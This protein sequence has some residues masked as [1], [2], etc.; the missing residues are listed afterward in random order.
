[1]GNRLYQIGETRDE[2]GGSHYELVTESSGGN[3]PTVDIDRAP[4]IFAAVHEAISHGLIRSCHDLSEG[5]LAA[6]VAEMAFAG[7]FGIDANFQSLSSTGLNDTILLFS[8]SNTRFIAEVEPENQSAFETCFGGLPLFAIGTVTDGDSVRIADGTDGFLGGTLHVHHDGHALQISRRCSDGTTQELTVN[9]WDRVM[10]ADEILA[11]IIGGTTRT[12]FQN[13]FAL[14]LSELPQ[15]ATL[16]SDEVAERLY[17]ATLGADGRRLLSAMRDGEQRRQKLFGPDGKSG[18]LAGLMKRDAKIAAELDALGRQREEYDRLCRDRANL[19]GVISEMK[20]RQAGMQSQLRGHRYLQRVWD[21]WNQVQE[22]E[23]ELATLSSLAEFPADGLNRLMQLETEIDSESRC[24]RTL[25]QE[26]EQLE[27]KKTVLL[28]D[29]AVLKNIGILR[30]HIGER[31]RM[32]NAAAERDTIRQ[33]VATETATFDASCEKL[34]REWNRKR[35]DKVDTSPAS[36]LELLRAARVYQAAIVRRGRFRKLY[37]TASNSFGKLRAKVERQREEF[38]EQ[39]VDAAVT[40]ENR[41]L[42]QDEERRRLEQRIG[43]TKRRQSEL[44]QILEREQ[45]TD[46]IPRWFRWALWVF[47]VAGGLVA[48]IGLVT[49]FSL[50]AWSGMIL[51]LAGLTGLGVSRG[52]QLHTE[53]STQ[54]GLLTRRAEL[55]R[56]EQELRDSTTELERAITD[57]KSDDSV[58][59][60]TATLSDRV[61]RLVDLGTFHRSA[62]R[63]EKRRRRMTQLRNRFSSVKQEFSLARQ[64]WCDE[65]KRAGLDTTLKLDDV[66]Y[67]NSELMN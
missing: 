61:G 15:L 62:Q 12:V 8:E 2:L 13:V 22:A 16:H 3:V 21:P 39:T 66:F 41:R 38:G 51:C 29:P 57:E 19:T 9:G 50:N 63:L 37:K 58:G 42:R 23:K 11:Q 48:L 44:T 7:G 36:Q 46:R 35:L 49:A 53:N 59:D 56:I 31:D 30:R 34:G 64:N 55:Q 47:V 43:D 52:L 26:I 20:S 33:T 14:G 10:A 54:D 24:R 60:S 27:A 4:R 6:A 67:R 5:G 1:A 32:Q 45:Q 65:L 28:P 40:L 17:G 25:R 18:T